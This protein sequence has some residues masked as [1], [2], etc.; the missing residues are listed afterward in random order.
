M[1]ITAVSSSEQN[2]TTAPGTKAADVAVAVR[3]AAK[4]GL[5]LLATWALA[6]IVRIQLPRH[7]GPVAFGNFSFADAYAGAFFVFVGFGLDTYVQKEVSV[8]PEHASDFFGGVVLVRTVLCV[9]LSAAMILSLVLTHRPSHLYGMALVFAITQYVMSFSAVL[10]SMLRAS[11]NV[12]VLATVSVVSKVLWAVGLVVGIALDAPLVVLAL[13]GLSGEVLRLVVLWRAARSAVGLRW[14][15]DVG[16]T[17]DVLLACL[18][19][20]ASAIVVALINRLDIAML[21]FIAPGPEVGWYRIGNVVVAAAWLD[22][23]AL[24]GSS[25][26]SVAR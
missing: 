3:N 7:L 8:R 13:S 22:T 17:K 19:Y 21:E 11:T 25:E 6:L 2:K 12:G 24:N 16:A 10:S 9:G 5:S 14:R 18:P 15:V 1:T 26:A 4:L 20:F 23:N